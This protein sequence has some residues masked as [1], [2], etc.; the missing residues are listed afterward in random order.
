[1]SPKQVLVILWRRLWIVVLTFAA[2]LAGAGGVLVLVPARYDAAATASIDP[3]QG[4]P[5]TGQTSGGGMLGILQGNLVALVKSQRVAVDVVKRLNLANSA[6]SLADYQ[7]SAAFGRVD[8]N[9]WLAGDIVKNVDAKFAL[10]TNVLTITY[11]SSSPVQGA[12]IAN[13]FLSSFIDAAV[14]M[15]V[16]SAQQIAQWFAPQMDKLRADLNAAR[17]KLAEFQREGKLLLPNSGGD[18]DSAQLMAVTAEL[19]SSKGALAVAESRLNAQTSGDAAANSTDPPDADSQL[20]EGLKGRAAATATE[21]G[22]LQAEVGPSNPKLSAL[23]ATLKTLQDQAHA[24]TVVIRDKL[25]ARIEQLKTQIQS[26]EVAR[27]NA[28]QEMIAVQAQRA[29]MSALTRE[30]EF[31]QEQ[32][33]AASKAEAQASL[34]SQLSFS[35]IS[36]LDEATPPVDPAFP[37][38]LLV[39]LGGV[40]LGLALGVIFAFLVESFDRRIRAES[41]LGFAVSAPLLGTLAS[42][43]TSRRRRFGRGRGKVVRQ[44]A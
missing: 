36:T 14:A 25:V 6:A 38:P 16:S 1:M 43:P 40:G 15:K 24:E 18:S 23:V 44:G 10:G 34:Q 12:L 7:N 13:T 42:A 5:I 3:G 2:T 8:I 17:D 26:L 32:V 21:I 19:S 4:D 11:K 20:L 39:E 35:N 27:S 22:K 30:V 9:E 31:R 29:R 33:D 37:K 41:D 28:Q